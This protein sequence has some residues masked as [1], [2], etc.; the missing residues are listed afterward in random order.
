MNNSLPGKWRYN[1]VFGTLVLICVGLAG[2][3]ALMLYE[4]GPDCAKIARAGQRITINLPGRPGEIYF[5][6][7][8]G[9][10]N[11]A[12][13]KQVPGC[14]IDPQRLDEQQ[15]REVL[16][17]LADA[18]NMDTLA[19]QDIMLAQ[20]DLAWKW[21]KDELT[22]Q[23]IEA[24]RQLNLPKQIP[25]GKI[26]AVC[27]ELSAIIGDDPQE[28]RK[29]YDSR[30]RAQFIWLKRNLAEE[31]VAAVEALK[32][33]KRLGG[34][35]IEYEWQRHYPNG[36]L[37]SSVVGYVLKDG[38][39]AE[40]M[41]AIVHKQLAATGGKRYNLGD[42]GRRHL[43]PLLEST[44]P[45]VNGSDVYLTIDTF[46][47]AA[48]EQAV[49]TSVQKH[50]AR[51]GVGVV[52]NPHT[53]EVLAMCTM[54]TFDPNNFNKVPKADFRKNRCFTD[55]YEPGSAFKPLIAA[56]AVD[57][58]IGIDWN[59]RFNCEGGT[60]STRN[61]GTITDHG[62]SYGL[63]SVTD[64]IVFSSNIGMAK[65]GEKLGNAAL[66]EI[67]HRFG[68]GKRVPLQLP[69]GTTWPGASAGIVRQ[70]LRSWD[71]YSLLRVPFGQE[72][73]V[74]AIQLANAYCALVN[75]GELLEPRLIDSVL[76]ASGKN[77]VWRGERKVIRRVLKPQT[78]RGAIDVM[79]QV[80][81]RGTG[82]ACKMDLWTS[83]GKTGTAQIAKD[84][85]YPERAFTSTF[86]GGAPASNPQLIC[87]I[88]VYWP[89][90]G[91]HYGST[92]AAPYVKD[93]LERSLSY[94]NVP[95]DKTPD[96][97][98]AGGERSIEYLRD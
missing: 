69:T 45:P 52:M 33:E 77:V 83:F 5:K 6:T 46:I 60:Y 63:L 34:L 20:Q 56:A 28:I 98:K 31:E 62:A 64:I 73:S 89:T 93:V 42:A 51:W 49:S 66:Y 72:I 27:L 57:A 55:P 38:T 70:P 94:L 53:G 54:P 97:A 30:R 1:F 81:E 35:G 44:K 26:E 88:S 10:L 2:Q 23:Q 25:A 36:T 4:A 8:Q 96:V 85:H 41:E 18:L 59:T 82:K 80:V 24:I 84:G 71:G 47:Q 11:A 68:F 86:V 92:V 14:F 32:K 16:P 19:L 15:L 67:V 12:T 87:V 90:K 79:A 95:P 61:G 29:R 43:V 40:G 17:A 39:P 76:D 9:F 37:A 75:G 65:I 48:L 22:D 74:T 91:G 50:A 78:S 3:L 13:S 21:I 58:G 7:H